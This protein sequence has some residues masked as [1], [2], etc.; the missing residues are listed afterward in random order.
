MIQINELQRVEQDKQ[1]FNTI[2][3]NIGFNNAVDGEFNTITKDFNKIQYCRAL[4]MQ[5]H[6]PSRAEQQAQQYI[7]KLK[8]GQKITLRGVY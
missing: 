8:A 2:C 1:R 4:V 6:K 3:E 5:Q 7:N